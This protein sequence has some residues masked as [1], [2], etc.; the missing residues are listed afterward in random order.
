MR[1]TLLDLCN[2]MLRK[3][4][5]PGILKEDIEKVFM[6]NKDKGQSVKQNCKAIGR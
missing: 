4:E 1:G 3:G 2:K 5:F 6:K